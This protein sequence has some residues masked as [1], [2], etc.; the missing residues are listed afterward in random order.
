[1]S[2]FSLGQIKNALNKNEQKYI[3]YFVYYVII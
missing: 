2:I 3:E 1:M